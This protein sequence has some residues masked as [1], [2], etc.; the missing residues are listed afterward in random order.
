MADTPSDRRKET[1][2]TDLAVALK[3]E[4]GTDPAPKVVAKGQGTMAEQ[5]VAIAKENG[6]E[7]REDAPL[8]EML[9]MLE[10][11]SLIPLEAYAAVAEILAYVYKTNRDMGS[12]RTRET[13]LDETL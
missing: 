6:I 8:V 2:K 5:I 9:S 10:I 12:R 11:D 4:H 3:Y 13:R 7:I 1:K